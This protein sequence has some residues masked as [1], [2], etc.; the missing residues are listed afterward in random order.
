MLANRPGHSIDDLLAPLSE[1]PERSA[2]LCDVDGTLAPIER[3]PE[4]VEVP[5]RSREILSELGSRYGL[6]A[7]V[8]GRQAVEARRIVGVTSIAYIGNHG[9]EYLP[10]GAAV[11]RRP[12]GLEQQ[13]EQVRAFARSSFDDELRAL[14]VRL[15]DKQAIW[16]FHWREV[17][18][19]GRAHTALQGVADSAEQHGLRPHWGRKVLEIRPPL[20]F[21]KGTAVAAA[22]SGVHARA[23]LYAGD[24]TTDL[25]AFRALRRLRSQGSL[26]HS[27]CV[28]VRSLEG[29]PA[30]V[31]DADLVVEGTGGMLDLLELLSSQ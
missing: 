8:S 5:E 14:G 10:P 21:D 7:C 29:P 20:Q 24:D 28:G 26:D 11:P 30:I 18:D 22:L 9:L 23:A 4:L 16:S 15:E 6:V 27:I 2:L 3:L 1:H 31:E 17:P 12:E 19:D 25:D 13:S